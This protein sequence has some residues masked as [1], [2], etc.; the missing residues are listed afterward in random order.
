MQ[1]VCTPSIV[2]HFV[3]LEHMHKGLPLLHETF[4]A[5]DRCGLKGIADDIEGSI[6]E[7]NQRW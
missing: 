1:L 6:N 3:Q 7:E 4:A 5:W 2:D